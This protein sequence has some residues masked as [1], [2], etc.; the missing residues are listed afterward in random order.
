M[1]VPLARALV[2]GLLT[3]GT[4]AFVLGVAAYRSGRELL[5]RVATAGGFAVFA[6]ALLIGG[7]QYATSSRSYR[8]VAVPVVIAAV[9]LCGHAIRLV[10]RRW[11]RS[12]QLA[13]V[14]AT[15][16]VLVVPFELYPELHVLAQAWYTSQTVAVLEL[17][18]AQPAVVPSPDGHPIVMQFENGFLLAVVR[19][20]NGIYAGA[21]FTAIVVGARTSVRRKLGGIAF[22]LGATFL[23]NQLRIVFVGLAMANDWFGP[24]LTDTNTLQM[25]YYVAEIGIGQPLVVVATV[26]GFLVVDRWIPDVLDFLTEL[27]SSIDLPAGTRP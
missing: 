26:S 20:C 8:V 17:L 7:S 14:M 16:L 24:L 22:A 21:L 11:S 18:G 5:G 12:R 13:T 25:T 27:L 23:V 1:S 4:A 6:L 9:L 3:G 2:V 10:Y 19:E 15:V